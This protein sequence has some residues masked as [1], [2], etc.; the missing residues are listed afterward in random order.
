MALAP[1]ESTAAGFTPGDLFVTLSQAVFKTTPPSGLFTLFATWA[2]VNGGCPNSDHSAITFD[3]VGTF[4]N[5]MIITCENGRVFTIDSFG[6]P[7]ETMPP[8]VTHLTD[9]TLPGRQ[10]SIEGPAVLP[11]SFGPLAGQIMVA[12][13]LN[14]NL[15]TINSVGNV[16]YQPFPGVPAGTFTG[17][18]QVLVI[19]QFPCVF[20]DRAFFS[21]S[22]VDDNI[23]SY[24][25]GDFTGLGGDILIT[26]EF[27]PPWGTFRV[28]FDV[29]SMSYQFFVFDGSA[30]LKEGS[31]FVADSCS[32]TPTPTPTAT[33]TPTNTPTPTSTPTATATSTPTATA[34]FTPTPT[35][36]PT[37]TATPSA[38]CSPSGIFVFE[39]N[40]A[41]HGTAGNIRTYTMNGITVKVSAFSRADSNGAWG[42]AYLGVYPNG[43]GVTNSHEGDGSNNRHTVGNLNGYRDYVLFEFSAPIIIDQVYL[44]FVVNDSDMAAWYGTKTDPI[45]NHNTLSDSFLS[46]LGTREDNDTT[47]TSPR[48]ADINSSNKI[49]NV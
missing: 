14:S 22:A 17:A 19:P 24:P 21:A 4:G 2:G 36:T 28:H 33:S 13:D 32:P 23:I 20:C 44:D 9:L 8:N 7:P 34:T 46:G 35:P 47:S 43:L 18:E 45:N 42:T 25:V 12:D 37:P 1:A 27:A 15:Y 3:K 31:T 26:S 48:W 41:T 5:K 6:V 10:I 11:A 38:T 30:F 40:S 49:G 16:N 29:P 39:G